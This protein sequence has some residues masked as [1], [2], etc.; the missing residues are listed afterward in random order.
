MQH[1]LVSVRGIFVGNFYAFYCYRLLPS[2]SAPLL[3]N[4]L[5]YANKYHLI[6]DHSN[7]H[8]YLQLDSR[9]S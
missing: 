1:V 9:C 2:F 3:V 4:S 7:V 8:F 6:M 5:V